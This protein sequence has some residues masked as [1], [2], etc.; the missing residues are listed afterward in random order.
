[1]AR[2][3]KAPTA[4]EVQVGE[5]GTALLVCLFH[6]N[7]AYSSLEEKHQARVVDRCYRPILELARSTEFPIAIEA[8]GWTLE[9]IAAL[10]PDWIE[11]CGELIG[12]GLV[13]LVGSAYAQCAGP[14]LP[15]EVNRWNLRLGVE[16][17]RRL[18]DV[19]PRVAL[20]GE[21]A[22]S[23]GL[24][25][26]YLEAGYQA[27]ITDWDNAYRSHPDWTPE[28]RR[29]PQRALGGGTSIP[30]IWSESIAFQKFQRFAHGELDLDRYL[31]Y[32][33]DATRSGG[34]LLLYG[35][36]AEVFDHRPARFVAEPAMREPEWERIAQALQA[37]R[38]DG[39]GEAILPHKLLADLRGAP[40]SGS[41]LQLESAAHPIPVKKQD[42][43]NISRWACTGRDDIA[44]NTRCFRV[45]D[46]MRAAGCQDAEAWRELCWLWASDFRTHITAR[47]WEAL[48]ER[49]RQAESRW[50]VKPPAVR[51]DE[52]G[53]Q[54]LAAD[55]LERDGHDL[56]ASAGSLSLR[57]NAR[58][59]LAISQFIDT[60]VD[61]RPLLGTLEHGYYPTIELGADFYTGHLVH[62]APLRHKVTDLER[63]DPRISRD[64][65]GRLRLSAEIATELG[66]IA[67]SVTLDPVGRGV[68]IDY[69]LHWPEL[70]TGSLRLGHVTLHPEAFDRRTLWFAA[71][72]GG[73]VLERHSL[74]QERIEHGS[75][76]SAL[77][78]CRQGLGAT[79][80]QVLLGD[81]DK[82][83]RVEFDQARSALFGLITY[84]PLQST[85]FFRLTLALAE[86]DETR[87]GPIPRAGE[88]QQAQIRLSALRSSA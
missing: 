77:V 55:A 75:P 69:A 59:G 3:A 65:A 5:P 22:Y 43:Y 34:A 48:T 78:S 86:S 49:L 16:A 18:L 81:A 54:P 52:R 57:V 62:E 12:A 63:V 38:A 76:V 72:N 51:A 20:V 29:A 14:L 47:R 53:W 73:E 24:V 27:I 71:H 17:Y 31:D 40:G 87:V 68:Q 30:V 85:Y 1:M 9:R 33:R 11:Q 28:I 50:Q 66:P 61:S 42:K 67:K 26:L 79:E 41:E 21:Q 83:I 46:R 19:T 58:R 88:P 74:G 80:G 70:P 2:P 32:V 15:A 84:V 64:P 36:D 23:P 4:E 13:E 39:L 25:P 37:I 7:L 45:F 82:T 56:L 6:L 60:R 10:A 44:I 35:N 8:S